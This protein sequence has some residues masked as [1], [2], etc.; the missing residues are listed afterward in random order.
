MTAPP[1]KPQDAASP[2]VTSPDADPNGEHV[3]AS[4]VARV[5]GRDVRTIKSWIRT[6][7]IAGF[8]KGRDWYVYRSAYNALRDKGNK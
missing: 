8:K 1:E 6:G 2:N 7:E 3:R 4:H 5:F